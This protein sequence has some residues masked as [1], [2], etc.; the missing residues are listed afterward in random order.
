MTDN[1]APE[2]KPCP[3]CGGEVLFRDIGT[4]RRRNSPIATRVSC[5]KCHYEKRIA[6]LGTDREKT[7]IWATEWWNTR[8]DQV[9]EVKI[10]MDALAVEVYSA[11]DRA[12]YE[13]GLKGAARNIPSIMNENGPFA[14]DI[15]KGILALSKEQGE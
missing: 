3:F 12:G 10:T 8:T 13:R 5:E 2:L 1:K 6:T 9:A 4:G 15:A 11:G 14:P 7:R